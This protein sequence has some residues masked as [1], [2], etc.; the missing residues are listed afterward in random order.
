[1]KTPLDVHGHLYEGLDESAADASDEAFRQAAAD[2]V[3]T[4]DGRQVA[5]LRAENPI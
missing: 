3:R 2:S 1:M 4:L 5:L